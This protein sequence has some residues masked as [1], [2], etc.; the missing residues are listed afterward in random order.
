MYEYRIGYRFAN[1]SVGGFFGDGPTERDSQDKAIA[2]IR[3]KLSASGEVFYFS[4]II[5]HRHQVNDDEYKIIN[6]GWKAGVHIPKPKKVRCPIQEEMLKM[7]EDG[8]G[9]EGG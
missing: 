3:R 8:N 4:S 5:E 1:G 6:E 7:W 2:V 9:G